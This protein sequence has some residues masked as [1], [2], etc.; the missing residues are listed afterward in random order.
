MT[1]ESASYISQLDTTL[2]TAADL[3]SEGDDHLR[4]TKTVLKTQFPNFG[5]TAIT[6]SAAEVNYSVGVTSAIQT[7]L[8]GKGAI[9]GQ[10]WTGAHSFAGATS[11]PTLAAGTNTTGAAST[12]FVQ[13]DF[14]QKFPNY[15][16]PVTASTTELNYLVGLTGAIQPQLSNQVAGPTHAATAKTT[17]VDADELG[18]LNSEASFGLVKFTFGQFKSWLA[19]LF[20][21]KTGAQVMTGDLTVPSV[22][23]GQLAGLRNKVINGD[24]TVWQRGTSFGTG[25]IYTADRWAAAGAAGQTVNQV[26]DHPINGSSGYCIEVVNTGGFQWIY[27]RIE[28]INLRDL[29]GKTV[30]ASC[31]VKN[32]AAGG[33]ANLS[34]VRANALDNWTAD[35]FVTGSAGTAATSWTQLTC[36]FTFTAAMANGLELRISTS[37]AGGAATVRVAAVQLEVGSAATSLESRPYGLELVLCQRYL[38]A[39]TGGDTTTVGVGT[40]KSSTQVYLPVNF[41]VEARVKPTGVTVTSAG[42][43][44]AEAAAGAFVSSAIGVT[45]SQS[46]K[47]GMLNV[48]VSGATAGQA[49]LCYLNGNA[50]ARGTILFTGCEL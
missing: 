23:G 49:A 47:I 28:S 25:N 37:A 5:T 6:A 36:S 46:T 30:T 16:A 27:Q 9:T 10:A 3:I 11:V 22:N 43:I 32:V 21:G 31:W 19:G 7:Q 17:P 48:T 35:T 42:M 39:V 1:V 41:P 18:Y 13:A 50:G 26:A 15:T 2:P 40:V 33:G 4:L 38:P 44:T 24:F 14:L 45:G 20:V 8:N 29:V 12:A 34:V